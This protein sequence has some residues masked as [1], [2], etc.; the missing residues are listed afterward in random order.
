MHRID[1]QVAIIGSSF[2][3]SLLALLLRRLGVDVALLDRDRH[4]RFAI[5]ESSTPAADLILADLCERYD[6]SGLKPLAKYG[7]WRETHPELRCGLKRGFSYFHHRPGQPVQ[8]DALHSTELLVTASAANDV[9]DTHWYRADVDA[10]FAAEAR[11]IGVELLEGFEISDVERSDGW[12]IRGTRDEETIEIRAPFVVDSSGSGAVLPKSLNLTERTESLETDS[13]CV[14]GHFAGVRRWSD[15]LCEGG[16]SAATHPFDCDAAALHHVL[17]GAWVWVLPFE[18]GITSVGLVLDS[19]RHQRDPSVSAEELWNACLARYPSLA[20][21]FRDARL[22][23]PFTALRST[24]RLQRLW[25]FPAADDWTLLPG[26]AGFIDPFYSTGIAH[27]LVGVERVARAFETR[28]DREQF[29]QR[30]EQHRRSTVAE[31]QL[32]DRLVADAYLTFGRNPTL[33]HDVSMLY[34]AAATTWERWRVEGT[35]ATTFLLADDTD[36]LARVDRCLERLLEVEQGGFSDASIE[37]FGRFVAGEIAPYNTAGLCDPAARNMY[38]YTAAEK[39]DDTETPR[40][41][42]ISG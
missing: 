30:L 23:A 4:P 11:R 40:T 6:L 33:L 28:T 5:G 24:G 21:Q 37:E 41:G 13:W 9:G 29:R 14:F 35:P 27:S 42:G 15:V 16:G 2:A 32:I 19:R 1:T 20:A 7:T 8:Q 17:D 12:T 3:G 34:F 38:R 39:G 10:F 36:W 18:G 31:L 26:T 22:V 25:N